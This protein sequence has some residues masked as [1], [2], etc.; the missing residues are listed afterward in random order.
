MCGTHTTLESAH[1]DLIEIKEKLTVVGLDSPKIYRAI[2]PLIE[3]LISHLEMQA[4]WINT[5]LNSADYNDG[6]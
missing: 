5:K 6:R 1:K 3:H 2:Q 4:R